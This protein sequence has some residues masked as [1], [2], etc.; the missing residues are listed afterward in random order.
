MYDEQKP[1]SLA[2]TPLHRKLVMETKF[3]AAVRNGR[4][5]GKD[6]WTD[7]NSHWWEW[8]SGTATRYFCID[9]SSTWTTLRSCTRIVVCFVEPL[10]FSVPYLSTAWFLPYLHFVLMVRRPCELE[11]YNWSRLTAVVS[12]I[13]LQI[14]L[15][16]CFQR[17]AT[18]L[19]RLNISST[20]RCVYITG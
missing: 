3:W 4:Q 5:K 13:R 9:T 6:A 12:F 2:R 18:A 16:C 20:V 8:F 7:L 19:K 14:F 15:N 1:E 17:L 11:L 10:L